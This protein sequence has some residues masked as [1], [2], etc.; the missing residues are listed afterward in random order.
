VARLRVQ[1][2]ADAT[3]CKVVTGP[4]E[5]TAI[6]NIIMQMLAMG[7]IISLDEGR[8]IIRNSFA[9]ESKTYQP[10]DVKAWQEALEKWRSICRRDSSLR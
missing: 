10:Q 8:S 6:G 1:F 9:H 2:A 3:G 4:I 7:D 5:A